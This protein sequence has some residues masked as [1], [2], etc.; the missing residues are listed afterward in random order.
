MGF[1]TRVVEDPHAAAPVTD[2]FMDFW[3]ATNDRLPALA[4]RR[5]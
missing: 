3:R 2:S 5:P 1:A 4:K